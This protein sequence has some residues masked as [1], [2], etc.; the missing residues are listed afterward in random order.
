MALYSSA[1]SSVYSPDAQ[2]DVLK[3]EYQQAHPG[4]QLGRGGVGLVITGRNTAR[5]QGMLL[6]GQEQRGKEELYPPFL[7]K[8]KQ[9]T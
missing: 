1:L 7:I 2:L 4:I 5:I 8:S 9:Q 6:K 3:N